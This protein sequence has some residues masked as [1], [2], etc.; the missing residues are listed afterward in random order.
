MKILL[1]DIETAPNLATVWGLWNQNIGIN[2]ILDAGYTLCWAAKWLGE[3]KI[4]FDSVMNSSPEV[5]VRGIH[6]LIDEA[7]AVIHYNGTKFDMPTLNKEFLLFEMS[8]PSP[9]KQID[10]LQTARK[11]F[12]FPSNKLDYVARSLGLG[13]KTKHTGHELWLKCMNKD[14]KAWKLMERYNKQDVKLLEKVYHR[15]LP[16]IKAH[17]NMGLYSENSDE[18]VCTN[19]GSADLQR[20]GFSRTSVSVYQRWQCN[21]CGSWQRTRKH[22]KDLY[23]TS[24]VLIREN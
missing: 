23:D 14:E 6:S 15:L 18:T 16:W 22:E 1:L 9:Y 5:M 10:L 20:R 4:S 21:A 17:P 12:R 24:K 3:R 2:Q 13:T 7:D 11:Q 19:C 8:P